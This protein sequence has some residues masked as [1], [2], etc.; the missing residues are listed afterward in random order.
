MRGSN[1]D[2]HRRHHTQR[3]CTTQQGCDAGVARAVLAKQQVQIKKIAQQLFGLAFLQQMQRAVDR[4]IQRRQ[5]LDAGQY[6]HQLLKQ[7]LRIDG[8]A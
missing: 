1:R 8:V 3:V 7:T 2:T 5:H 4:A 6:L